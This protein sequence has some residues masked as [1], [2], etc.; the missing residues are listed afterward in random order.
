M[1][2]YVNDSTGG[3]AHEGWVT[4]L[5]STDGATWT[6]EI[7][8]IHTTTGSCTPNSACGNNGLW[9]PN[10]IKNTITGNYELYTVNIC[11]L[12]IERR[13]STSLTD[14]SLWGASAVQVINIFFSSVGSPKPRGGA[15]LIPDHTLTTLR[16]SGRMTGRLMDNGMG[17]FLMGMITR[18]EVIYGIFRPRMDLTLMCTIQG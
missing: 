4:T 11:L 17:L 15:H 8:I 18:R 14:A 16:Y 5:Q 13:I 1:H 9:T 3:N 12:Q 6:N 2:L 10:V 7:S